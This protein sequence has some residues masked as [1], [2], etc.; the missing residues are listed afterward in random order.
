MSHDEHPLTAD[1]RAKWPTLEPPNHFATSVATAWEHERR[2]AVDEHRPGT[3]RVHWLI[4]A[5]LAAALVLLMWAPWRSALTPANGERRFTERTSVALSE[6]AVVVGEP[7]AKLEWQIDRAGEARIDQHAG[8]VFYR[9]NPGPSFEVTTPHGNVNVTG[10]CFR[11]EVETMKNKSNAISGVIGAIV[12]TAVTVTVYEGQVVLA[13]DDEP[14][15]LGPGQRATMGADAITSSPEERKRRTNIEPPPTESASTQELAAYIRTQSRAIERLQAVGK[16][17]TA[18]VEAL[19]QQVVD[20]GATPAVPGKASEVD[21]EAKAKVCAE[22]GRRQAGCSF[23]EPSQATLLEMA[24]CARVR[25]D[26]PSLMGDTR[27][28]ELSPEDR[29]ALDMSDSEYAELRAAVERHRKSDHDTFRQFYVEAGGGSPEDAENLSIGALTGFLE[30]T[31]DREAVS[32][33]R[34]ELAYERAGLREP[35]ASYD[36]LSLI[37][38]FARFQAERGNAFEAAVAS[39]LGRERARKWRNKEDGWSGNTSVWGSD[40]RDLPGE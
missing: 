33:A 27:P 20:L 15:V 8:A 31:L 28:L 21:D 39:V 1:E 12:A 6:R 24:R 36:D 13:H 34:R 19:R 23:V 5:T 18:E 4:P 17:Q 35:P 38:R 7:G 2:T 11:I 37:E 25:D 40:C 22:G 16:S 30:D 26:T 14:V 10:T 9:V 29:L 32:D 3:M